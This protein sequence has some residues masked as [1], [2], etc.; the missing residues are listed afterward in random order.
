MKEQYAVRAIVYLTPDGH[1]PPNFSVG[2]K[3]TEI[4]SILIKLPIAAH[5]EEQNLASHVL[6]EIIAQYH[7][8]SLDTL[9][10]IRQ[11]GLFL[12][13]IRGD[14]MVSINSK[15]F[16]NAITKEDG[17]IDKNLFDI[18]HRIVAQDIQWTPAITEKIC[19]DLTSRIQNDESFKKILQ[20]GTFFLKHDSKKGVEL[21]FILKN[22]SRF[23]MSLWE[24]EWSANRTIE[25]FYRN[26]NGHPEQCEDDF[27]YIKSLIQSVMDKYKYG[28][29]VSN[30]RLCY[31]GFGPNDGIQYVGNEDEYYTLVIE[32]LKALT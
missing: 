21:D 25:L 15:D 8:D 9:A 12:K 27:S 26:N 5:D 17:T 1:E 14:Y 10:F 2:D 31:G 7:I 24:R 3:K 16:V 19:H 29:E 28:I 6:Y 13:K 22:G 30:N 23:G 20:T 32:L 4:D 18:A 11:Y